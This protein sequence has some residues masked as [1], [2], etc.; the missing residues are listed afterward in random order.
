[1]TVTLPSGTVRIAKG[2][3]GLRLAGKKTNPD[4]FIE[5][6]DGHFA[7]GR[8][9]TLCSFGVTKRKERSPGRGWGMR[10]GNILRGQ[11]IQHV[12]RTHAEH[13]GQVIQ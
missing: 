13:A 12:R 9:C 6:V 3:Q 11:M 7:I 8:R 5:K 4:L 1:M 10:E 2:F